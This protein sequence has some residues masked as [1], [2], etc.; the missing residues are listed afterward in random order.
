MFE[1][2]LNI[3]EA[4]K[5]AE[6]YE[7]SLAELTVLMRY[8]SQENCDNWIHKLKDIELDRSVGNNIIMSS[9]QNGFA[10]F[11]NIDDL[12]TRLHRN[13]IK[14]EN[15]C[16]DI[17]I[18]DGGQ[19]RSVLYLKDSKGTYLD[20][21]R[22]TD[23]YIFDD[24]IAYFRLINFLKENEHREDRHFYFVD[25]FNVDFRKIV[26]TSIKKEG[27][28]TV[29]YPKLLPD[30]KSSSP[31][32]LRI[33]HFIS[34]FEEKQLPKFIKLEL[35]NFLAIYRQEERLEA[36]IE[37]LP[38]ILEKAEQNFEIYL[39]DLSLDNFKSHF[40]EFRIKYFNQFRDIF[41]KLTT[42]ILAFPL[43]IT[44][45]SFAAYKTIDSVLLCSFIV[46][47]FVVFS[48]YSLFMLKAHKDDIVEIQNLFE[49]DYC[50]FVANPFFVKYPQEI[51]AFQNTRE[52]ITRRSEFLR[53]CIN[54]YSFVLILTN[55]LFVLF[56]L[57]QV[58]SLG[59]SV[60]VMLSVVLLVIY[61]L[62][63]YA[64]FR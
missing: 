36:F 64:I 40:L 14:G 20:F 39:S 11:K 61:V 17:L 42:Q 24:A 62:L 10:I 47:A 58:L 2:Y 19:N 37:N 54:V 51:N 8:S 33:E 48:I 23:Y 7:F 59:L 35:F 29:G 22:V 56:I 49:S 32:S 6:S 25:Y 50:V 43:S 12:R 45:A 30:F 55:L 46:L 9:T 21:K 5:C 28:L 34:A 31:I 26:F 41:S 53:A 15:I 38:I 57:I 3:C 18:L 60:A 63:Y 4:I 1:L 52:Y 13:H 16:I 27:K 44:A